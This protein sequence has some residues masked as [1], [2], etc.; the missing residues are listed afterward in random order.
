MDG[1][2][3]WVA[4]RKLQNWERGSRSQ[5]HPAATLGH[6]EESQPVCAAVTRAFGS[7][8]PPVPVIAEPLALISLVLKERERE[9]EKGCEVGGG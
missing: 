1:S 9:R 2:R 8:D 3:K 4:G 6:L 7:P 5:S